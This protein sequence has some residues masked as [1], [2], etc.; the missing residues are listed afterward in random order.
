MLSL[1]STNTLNATPWPKRWFLLGVAALAI[2]GV[3]SVVLV[4]ARTPQLAM[5]KDLFSMS[6]VIHVD[7]SVLVWF[8]A[9]GG[10]MISYIANSHT[11][12]IPYFQAGAFGCAAL[13]TGLMALSPADSHWDVIK[14]NYIPV[15][16][17]PVF[18]A[19]LAFLLA[20]LVVLVLP[21]L[22]RFPTRRSDATGMIERAIHM[23]AWIIAIAITCFVLTAE[24]LPS[25]LPRPYYFEQLF[26]AGGHVLQFAY[27]QSAMIGWLLLLAAIGVAPEGRARKA[28]EIAFMISLAAAFLCLPAFVLYPID[29]EQFRTYFTTS[30]IHSGGIAPLIVGGY[31]ICVLA[32]LG[33]P[34]RDVRG[35]YA[36]LVTSLVLFMSGGIIGY[37][38]QG[39]NVTI[40][41]HYHGSIVGVTLAMMGIAYVLLPQFGYRA[42]AHTKLALWQP[43]LYGV[44]ALMHAIGLAVSGGYGVMRKSTGELDGAAKV[45]MGIM[46]LGG[47]LAIIGGVLF[48]VIVIRS[49]RGAK[50]AQT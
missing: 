28:C 11:R 20:A 9:M 16:D 13:A 10:A 43:I 25:G 39:Q 18:L 12:T 6:L 36:I 1:F 38:I 46:G 14:S 3:F 24:L 30:M 49:I 29:S 21:C 31:A 4:M 19:G 42:I 41:A 7:L 45:T 37:M 8:L 15:L 2:A 35:Y 44:G 33:K 50:L 17:N 23:G 34:S 26:W 27:T 40:P 22:T 32:R 47:M 48:I 5:F